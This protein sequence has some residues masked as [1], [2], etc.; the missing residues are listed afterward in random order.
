MVY[1]ISLSVSESVTRIVLGGC[2]SKTCMFCWCTMLRCR[3]KCRKREDGV[4]GMK[5]TSKI[6]LGC[7]GLHGRMAWI[8]GPCKDGRNVGTIEASKEGKEVPAVPDKLGQG[9][10]TGTGSHMVCVLRIVR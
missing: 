10:Y 2:A 4:K 1:P 6:D 5:K 8:R 9:T 7:V 3:Q